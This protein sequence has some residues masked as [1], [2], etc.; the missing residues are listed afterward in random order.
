MTDVFWIDREGQG[1]LGIM[2][3]PRGG[4]CLSDEIANLKS[5]GVDILVSAITADEATELELEHEQALCEASGV[6][7]WD[8]P[9]SDRSI[10]SLEVG[11]DFLEK[12]SA[13]MRQGRSVVIHCR[14]GVGR[15]GM[16]CAGVLMLESLAPYE[17]LEKVS[18]ARGLI[19]PD[20]VA[21]RDWLFE[22]GERLKR[23]S[24]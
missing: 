6:E 17:A 13:A 10:P 18:N 24:G 19:V 16:L 3:R 23:E 7:Y 20:T 11:H 4:E 9:I 12:A 15:S 2:P 21:Q 5:K 1:R 8:F 22:L 14:F